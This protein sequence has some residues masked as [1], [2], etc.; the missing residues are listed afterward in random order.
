MGDAYDR[1]NYI[2]FEIKWA[3]RPFSRRTDAIGRPIFTVTH[4]RIDACLQS[5][6]DPHSLGMSK[7]AIILQVSSA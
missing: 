7:R 2:S 3:F 6:S 5:I 4:V 1:G